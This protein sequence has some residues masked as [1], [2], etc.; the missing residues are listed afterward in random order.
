[1]NREHEDSRIGKLADLDKRDGEEWRERFEPGT[2][3]CHEA[4]DRTALIMNLVDD[5]TMHPAI[6]MNSEWHGLAAEAFD[7]LYDLYQAIGKDHLK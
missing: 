7:K 6:V 5:L 4:L 3:G 1:M 2:H